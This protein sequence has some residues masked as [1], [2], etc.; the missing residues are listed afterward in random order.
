M[1]VE[2]DYF[3]C[4][5]EEAQFFVRHLHGSMVNGR[6]PSDGGLKFLWGELNLR[7]GYRDSLQLFSLRLQLFLLPLEVFETVAQVGAFDLLSTVALDFLGCIEQILPAKGY[8]TQMLFKVLLLSRN[9]GFF[10]LESIAVLE[11]D[12]C[13]FEQDLLHDFLE[14]L[15]NAL[16]D[17]YL[18]LLHIFGQLE[19]AIY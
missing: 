6:Y 17:F 9:S 13:L 10:E 18:V 19:P 16:H 11:L 14:V 12:L 2:H 3:V 5:P 7:V 8:E 4:V 1:Q 15:V